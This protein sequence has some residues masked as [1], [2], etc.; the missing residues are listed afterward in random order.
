MGALDPERSRIGYPSKVGSGRGQG[1]VGMGHGGGALGLE[2]GGALGLERLAGG[3]LGGRVR[4]MHEEHQKGET[5]LPE[6]VSG[7]QG[8]S[9]VSTLIG[10]P[11]T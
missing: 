1:R 9:H 4:R 8:T 5:G 10:H 2:G 3:R 6:A 7:E 11:R